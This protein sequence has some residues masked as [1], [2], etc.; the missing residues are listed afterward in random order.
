MS[1]GEMRQRQQALRDALRGFRD[2]MRG[3][4]GDQP[5][6]QTADD[7]FGRAEEAMRD[8]ERALQGD[9]PGQ[10]SDEQMRA[11]EALRDGARAAAEAM[12]QQRR[13]AQQNGNGQ[14]GENGE[15][16]EGGA[17]RAMRDPFGR[18]TGDGGA[19]ESGDYSVP[20][21]MSPSRARELLQELRK[22]AGELGRPELELEYLQRLLE[23]FR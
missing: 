16:G 22:R 6:G 8:A 9:D 21:E 12:E 7:A 19:L 1:L 11:V 20:G 2:G 13:Q 4:M 23:R 3:Q 15:P 17:E 14:P 18:E 5:Q 10:A